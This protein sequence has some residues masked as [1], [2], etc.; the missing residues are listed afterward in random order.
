MLSGMLPK[1]FIKPLKAAQMAPS[2][3]SIEPQYFQDVTVIFVEIC[4]FAQ[5]C[6]NIPARDVVEVL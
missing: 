1:Q 3:E 2:S 5:L 4:D 6:S